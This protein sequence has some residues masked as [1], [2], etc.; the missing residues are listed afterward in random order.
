MSSPHSFSLFSHDSAPSRRASISGPPSP[1]A[2]ASYSLF[3]GPSP[4]GPSL[5]NSPPPPPGPLSSPRS[6]SPPPML[7]PMPQSPASTTPSVVTP[8]FN[9]S[10]G[11]GAHSEVGGLRKGKTEIR[12]SAVESVNAQRSKAISGGSLDLGGGPL[13]IE[14][15]PRSS[16]PSQFRA[17]ATKTGGGGASGHT[18]FPLSSA[19]VPPVAL[20]T[21]RLDASKVIDA[22]QSPRAP[23]KGGSGGAT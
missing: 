21:A 2:S 23:R 6:A 12:P 11:H 15:V 5:L 20:T 22:P 9:F 10:Q 1:R 19:N 18:S 4:F 13:N 7:S 8:P 17:I 14:F 3:S 16:D